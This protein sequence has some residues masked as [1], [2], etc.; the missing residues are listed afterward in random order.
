LRTIKERAESIGGEALIKSAPGEGT[1]VI[2][3]VPFN[4]ISKT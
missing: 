1:K 3:T 4:G 2:I